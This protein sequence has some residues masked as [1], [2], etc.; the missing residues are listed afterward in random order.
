MILLIVDM[1]LQ[2][3]LLPCTFYFT[4]NKLGFGTERDVLRL[5]FNMLS[6]VGTSIKL[7]FH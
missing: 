3:Q 6:C 2:K 7:V 1:F 4:W 5:E